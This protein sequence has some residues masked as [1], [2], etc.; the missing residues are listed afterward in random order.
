MN[1]KT[2]TLTTA[3]T[4]ILGAAF[5]VSRPGKLEIERVDFG[6]TR[7][8][9]T[10]AF[11]AAV[12]PVSRATIKEFRIPM[13]Q[14]TIE[15][16]SGVRYVGWTFGGTVPGPVIRVRQGDLVRINLVN[17]SGDMPHSIDFHASKIPMNTAMK[18]IAPGDSLQFEFEATTPGVFMVHC[19]TPPVLMHIAQGMYLPIIVDP[20]NGWPT[21]ADKEFVLVQSDFYP[22]ASAADST[23]FQG[24]WDAMLQARP[25]FVVFNGRAFQYQKNPLQ[26][27]EGDR[28]R[29]FVMNAGPN[30]RSD[31]HVVGNIFERVY[32]GGNPD[33]VIEGV[34]TYDVP[35]GGGAV[36]ELAFAK[37]LSG[38]GTYAFVTH[39]FADASKGA[40]GLIQVGHPA[41]M[42]SH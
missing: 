18:S 5:W 1:A 41:T 37:G 8:S 31:F 11:D 36:F 22:V 38:E 6:V 21:R 27:A 28:V 20:R 4:L 26:V 15:I 12:A 16:A 17:L 10:P 25:R 39:A 34:Q 9:V 35:T 23:L 14:D 40:V 29:I 42:A 3:A 2:M 13:T 7:T 32:P 30:I 19:G 24:D 33:Q